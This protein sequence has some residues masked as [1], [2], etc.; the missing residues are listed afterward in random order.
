[1]VIITENLVN[2]MLFILAV[3]SQPGESINVD[4]LHGNDIKANYRLEYVYSDV[5]EPVEV[6]HYRAS[7][8]INDKWILMGRIIDLSNK[9]HLVWMPADTSE[10]I[11]VDTSALR[12]AIKANAETIELLSEQLSVHHAPNALY[13]HKDRH[14]IVIH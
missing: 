1:M 6:A 14:T 8:L 5:G 2:Y 7:Q 3:I 4:V 12:E 10:P 9:K 11:L 13:L